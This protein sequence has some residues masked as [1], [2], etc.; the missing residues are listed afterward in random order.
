MKHVTIPT[1]WTGEEALDVVGFLEKVIHA[2][3]R[4]HGGSMGQV[5]YR[6]FHLEPVCHLEPVYDQDDETPF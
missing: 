1:H 5:L 4:A 3:W 6:D 2:I